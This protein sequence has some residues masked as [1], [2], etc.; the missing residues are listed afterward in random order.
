MFRYRS[1]SDTTEELKS[2]RTKDACIGDN[3][4]YEADSHQTVWCVRNV[5][6]FLILL[7]AIDMVRWRIFSNIL[8]W[9]SING[10]SDSVIIRNYP[11]CACVEHVGI[12]VI[13]KK[14]FHSN[15]DSAEWNPFLEWIPKKGFFPRLFTTTIHRFCYESYGTY[16]IPINI[17]WNYS[18][19]LNRKEEEFRIK[20]DRLTERSIGIN[21]MMSNIM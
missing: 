4:R 15:Y 18:N 17:E 3:M 2:K 19:Y 7:L 6:N 20:K 16:F 5:E 21:R 1:I 11:V 13:R 10:R 12:M 8:S 9:K 14:M